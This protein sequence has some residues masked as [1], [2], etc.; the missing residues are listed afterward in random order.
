[1]GPDYYAALHGVPTPGHVMLG[2]ANK[3]NNAKAG[4][5]LL[6][7]RHITFVF[8]QVHSCERQ[9]ELPKQRQKR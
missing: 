8:S 1:M 6:V 9:P 4:K 2:Q 5:K 7:G 3:L